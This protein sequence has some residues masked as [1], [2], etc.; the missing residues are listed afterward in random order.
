VDL[1]IVIVAFDEGE[2]LTPVLDELGRQRGPGDEVVVVHNAG[3]D[4]VTGPRT[5]ELAAAHPAVD[6]VVE[7]G[8]NL[9]FP[10]GAN[11]GAAATTRETILF[12]NPDA[13]PAPGC[14]DAL[15]EPPDGWD[16]WQ[17][18]VVLPDGRVNTAGGVTHYTGFGWTGRYLEP[19]EGVGTDP[20]PVGFLSGA[21]L[22]IRRTA[23]EAVGGFP[24]DFFL[25]VD[26]VDI[27]HRLR[28]QGRGFGLV[29]RARVTHDYE[30]GRRPD[31]LRELERNRLLMIV[32]CYPGPVLAAVFPALVATELA[33]IV[34]AA[35]GGWGGAKLRG[36]AGFLRALPGA[37]RQRREIQARAAIAPGEF[38][39]A[40]VPELD[41]PF[42]G[43]LGR[44]RLVRALLRTY[45]SLARRALR[46]PAP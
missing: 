18:L 38:A 29:P 11:V 46:W 24:D 30:F 9:G 17:G 25:Y 8:A 16:A 1:A 43:G 19:A 39:A 20:R 5:A 21:C 33:L 23:W 42:F 35:L 32:R 37:L 31:K 7:T 13:L 4:P 41:S 36:T 6:R 14:L 26:D 27:T 10:R 44:S 40:L 12:L 15:R 34:N 45:W 28:L 22:A 3:G 2:E